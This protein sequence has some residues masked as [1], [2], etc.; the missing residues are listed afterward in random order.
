MGNIRDLGLGVQDAR[1]EAQRRRLEEESRPV[2]HRLLSEWGFRT[3][4]VNR[5]SAYN[6]GDVTE[7][8]PDAA[9]QLDGARA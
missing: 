8:M 7:D 1:E 3:A 2:T 9:K 6:D 5:S 4:C